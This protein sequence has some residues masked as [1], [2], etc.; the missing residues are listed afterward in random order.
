MLHI[1]GKK[2]VVGAAIGRLIIGCFERKK[3]PYLGDHGGGILLAEQLIEPITYPDLLVGKL[4]DHHLADRI[5]FLVLPEYQITHGHL[6]EV[7]FKKWIA[8]EF[9]FHHGQALFQE[10][11]LLGRTSVFHL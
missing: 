6:V 9:L 8:P 5:H 4:V 11:F 1:V 7:P 3:L 10:P 2:I